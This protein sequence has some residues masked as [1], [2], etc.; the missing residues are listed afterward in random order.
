MALDGGASAW[1][2]LEDQEGD[3]SFCLSNG[4]AACASGS[5]YGISHT[6]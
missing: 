4:S 3:L 5:A 6:T 1:Y 2:Y